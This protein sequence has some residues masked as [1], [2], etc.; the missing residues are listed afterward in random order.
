MSKK[1]E[2]VYG[3]VND[4]IP[5]F[6]LTRIRALVD[7]PLHRVKAGDLG[8]FVESEGNLSHDGQAWIGGGASV[9]EQGR[10]QDNALAA[11][12]SMVFGNARLGGSARIYDYAQ[13]SG[14]ARLYGQARMSGSACMTDDAEAFGNSAIGGN[15]FLPAGAFIA[16]HG[17]YASFD[18]AGSPD[19]DFVTVY[20]D[21]N[22]QLMVYCAALTGT[23][24]ECLAKCRDARPGEPLGI[25]GL[26]LEAVKLRMQS[27][28]RA[29]RK[30]A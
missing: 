15:T 25:H 30:A 20:T 21:R 12:S 26:M 28:Q 29:L 18:I 27:A 10:V 5:G 22:G 13:M 14:Q 8:G 2:L 7:I 4:A 1:F 16:A 24:D 3:D 19:D 11:G 23:L 6:V 17:Q 9:Y